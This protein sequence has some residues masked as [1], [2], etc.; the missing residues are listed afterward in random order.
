MDEIKLAYRK[1]T[2]EL[3]PDKNPDDPEAAAKFQLL[4][5]AYESLAD[6]QGKRNFLKYGN[7]DGPGSLNIGIALPSFLLKKEN[8]VQVLIVFFL[9][10]LLVIPGIGL[11]WHNS[12]NRYNHYGIL[13]D[14]WQQRYVHSFKE[15]LSMSK[16]SFMIST[17]LEFE[18]ELSMK[19]DESEELNKVMFSFLIWYY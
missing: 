8:Q 3:H 17:S 15:G 9:V 14:N 4:R 2:R 7:P 12:V 1:L 16:I 5:K 11:Y 13:Q 6:E 18:E 19:I 10:L